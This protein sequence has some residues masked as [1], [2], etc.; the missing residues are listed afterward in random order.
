MDY[1]AYSIKQMNRTIEKFEEL[2]ESQRQRISQLINDEP[3]VELNN[4]I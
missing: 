1:E 3:E 4:E 2:N